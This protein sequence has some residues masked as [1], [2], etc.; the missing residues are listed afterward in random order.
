M[1]LQ[2]IAME[3]PHELIH[4]E[5]N[6]PTTTQALKYKHIDTQTYI[7]LHIKKTHIDPHSAGHTHTHACRETHTHF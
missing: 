3:T 1:D 2:I 4:I 6:R 5:E 7:H